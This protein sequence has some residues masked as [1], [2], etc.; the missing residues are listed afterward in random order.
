MRRA[1]IKCGKFDGEGVED[2]WES[3]CEIQE[4]G[5]SNP[6]ETQS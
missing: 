4:T 5:D 2:A 6:G 3:K 1:V